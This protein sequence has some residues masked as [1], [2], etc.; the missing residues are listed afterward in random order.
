MFTDRRYNAAMTDEPLPKPPR[1]PVTPAFLAEVAAKQAAYSAQRRR[2]M[3]VWDR[4]A[5]DDDDS[6]QSRTTPP[7]TAAPRPAGFLNLA[8]RKRTP[9]RRADQRQL[10]LPL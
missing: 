2:C 4:H 7:L 6:D 5:D 1:V 3:A 10:L 9:Q 8:G